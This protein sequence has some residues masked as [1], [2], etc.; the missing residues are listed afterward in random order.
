MASS[1]SVPEQGYRES[2]RDRKSNKD[3]RDVMRNQPGRSGKKEA[4]QGKGGPLDK[5]PARNVNYQV[6]EPKATT[7]RGHGPGGNAPD[8]SGK[9]TASKSNSDRKSKRPRRRKSAKE[10]SSK[11]QPTPA[12]TGKDKGAQRES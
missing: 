12:N 10:T 6:K 9:R 1:T 11:A 2:S 4:H 5:K 8:S 3:L 7:S